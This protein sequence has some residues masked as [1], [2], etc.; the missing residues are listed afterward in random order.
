MISNIVDLA[1]TRP[2]M[3]FD[4]RE[5]HNH[6]S[7]HQQSG[8][9]IWH[10]KQSSTNLTTTITVSHK[11]YQPRETTRPATSD[12]GRSDVYDIDIIVVTETWMT[13]HP[14][15]HAVD[16]PGYTIFRQD[17]KKRRGGG[18]AVCARRV[19][20]GRMLNFFGIYDDNIE[21]ILIQD[22][23]HCSWSLVLRRRGAVYH[24]PKSI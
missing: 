15:D 19:F 14:S 9:S 6:M 1:F 12:I 22:I 16:I 5:K 3:Q 13:A 10:W 11:S 2:S 18:I 20:N 21:L 17:R 8:I 23:S 24:P 7:Y 4:A